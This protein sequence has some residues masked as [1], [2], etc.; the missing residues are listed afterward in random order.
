VLRAGALLGLC[1]SAHLP[2][3]RV[4]AL[5][6]VVLRLLGCLGEEGVGGRGAGNVQRRLALLVGGAVV[7]RRHVVQPAARE[8]ARD[9]VAR[10]A[11][12]RQVHAVFSHLSANDYAT[13]GNNMEPFSNMAVKEQKIYFFLL[14]LAVS[15]NFLATKKYG[16][17]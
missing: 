13:L 6:F 10:H 9:R 4:L 17:L 5:L 3:R 12:G 14:F 16:T 11:M 8:G 2:Y 15:F 1:F 7:C